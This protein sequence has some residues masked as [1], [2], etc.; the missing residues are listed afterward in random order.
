[1]VTEKE[2]TK[3]EKLKHVT[4][5]ISED[6]HKKLKLKSVMDGLTMRE[7]MEKL[8]TEAVCVKQVVAFF[9]KRSSKLYRT[10]LSWPPTSNWGPI[11]SHERIVL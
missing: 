5:K 4:V 9:F 2:T 1:M 7:L 11:L 10:I 3:K 8:I 6:I